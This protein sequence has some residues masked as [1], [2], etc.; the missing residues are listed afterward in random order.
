MTQVHRHRDRR[1][2]TT[3]AD[4][5]GCADAAHASGE[6]ISGE[7]ITVRALLRR[8]TALARG[9]SQ[10]GVTNRATASSAEVA[11]KPLVLYGVA[12]GAAICGSFVVGAPLTDA[13]LP[14]SSPMSEVMAALPGLHKETPAPEAAFTS[15]RAEAGEGTEATATTRPPAVIASAAVST[16]PVGIRAV[17]LTIPVPPTSQH[18]E[19]EPALPHHDTEPAPPHRSAD[20]APPPSPDDAE[21]SPSQDGGEQPPSSVD[22]SGN[23]SAQPGDGDPAPSDGGARPVEPDDES[24]NSEA[25]PDHSGNSGD[26]NRGAQGGRHPAEDGDGEHGGR[27]H[28]EEG[29]AATEEHNPEGESDRGS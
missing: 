29:N 9:W 19:R 6:D 15:T 14:D 24:D 25:Q 17:P 1:G 16:P 4:L 11:S 13:V 22:G 5:M 28:A 26:D 20:P 12:V 10:A 8:E 7:D 18:N 21:Q 2:A 27:H 23:S 3:V